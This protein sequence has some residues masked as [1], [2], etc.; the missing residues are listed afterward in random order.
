ML[1]S[2]SS[3]TIVG[4]LVGLVFDL[5]GCVFR[6]VLDFM[7]GVVNGVLDLAAD[8]HAASFRAVAAVPSL[9]YP[10]LASP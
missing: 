6:R 9:A 4:G 5:A 8:A 7:G 1:S 3:W 10:A 2:T